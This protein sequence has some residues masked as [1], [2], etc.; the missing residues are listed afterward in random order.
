MAGHRPDALLL[1]YWLRFRDGQD[2]YRIWQDGA[3][4]GDVPGWQSACRGAAWCAVHGGSPLLPMMN[5]TAEDMLRETYRENAQR[6]IFLY[7]VPVEPRSEGA[8]KAMEGKT[9]H[10]WDDMGDMFT[11]ENCEHWPVPVGEKATSRRK[12]AMREMSL[13][14]RLAH[15]NKDIY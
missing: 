12:V 4:H 11:R 2:A 5:F 9:F 10:P 14:Y 13:A 7:Y 1:G 6:G 15:A 3:R 8:H